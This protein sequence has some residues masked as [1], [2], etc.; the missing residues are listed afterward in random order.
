VT[1]PSSERSAV[2]AW[3]TAIAVAVVGA[4]AAVGLIVVFTYMDDYIGAFWSQAIY[5]AAFFVGV[6]G[7]AE[8]SRR[9][10]GKDPSRLLDATQPVTPAGLPGPFVCTQAFGVLG[11]AMIVAGALI[12]GG[13]GL[14]WI[15]SGIV[16]A[17]VGA[18]GLVFWGGTMVSRRR[19]AQ[20][21]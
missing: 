10:D 1:Q 21:R 18:V 6:I 20:R 9:L 2:Y 17:L 12:G 7:L 8:R 14:I 15:F 16:L 4:A 19:A 11:L 13:R 5:F 3:Q